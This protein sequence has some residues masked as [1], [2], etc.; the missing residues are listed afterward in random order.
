M[1]E[2][3]ARSASLQGV[4]RVLTVL[5]AFVGQAEWRVSDLAKH[6]GIHKAVTHRIVRS[7]EAR[8]YLEQA[9][10]RGSYS[11]GPAAVA[12]GRAAGRR[13]PRTTA[14]RH[15][16]RLAEQTGEVVLFYTLR[17][18][19][20]VCVERLDINAETAV[21]V[22]IGDTIGLNAGAGKTLL[23]YQDERFLQEVLGAP[24]PRYTDRTPTDP[25]AIRDMLGRIRAQGYWV[26]DG[27]ITP[28]TVG[29]SAPVRDADGGVRHCVC[30][31]MLDR[32]VDE[33][34]LAGVS[35]AVRDTATA[36]SQSLG[37]RDGGA[38]P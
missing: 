26:S 37:H 2:E 20:Y 14:R 21:T 33:R 22:E 15:L 29:V 3:P 30:V 4:D 31:T 25:G 32:R 18:H 16:I 12:L 1:T 5:E 35:A 13:A 19:R 34:R 7:L 28:G 8:H 23:A 36:V 6:L 9:E 17:G 27:E 10:A 24:L 38:G 11:L